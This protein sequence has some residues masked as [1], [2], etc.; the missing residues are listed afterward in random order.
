MAEVLP[1][2]LY[3]DPVLRRKARPVQDFS[4]LA[5]LAENMVETMFEY[6]GVGLAAPQVGLSRRLFVAA[7]YAL[8]EEE[9]EADEEERPKSVLKN[10]YVMANPR[11]THREGT[12]VGTEGCLSIPG[13]YS[14]DVPRDL[15]IRVEYQDVTGEP[16]TLEAEGYLARV[17]QHELDHLEGVLFLDRIPAELRRPFMEEHRAELAEMQRKAKAFLREL[18]AERG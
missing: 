9:A 6:G 2:R 12:Q 15:Q 10:L 1:I 3:G 7:E 8:E 5:E 17:I 4:D 14:D 13:V 11:I 16:R 18:R